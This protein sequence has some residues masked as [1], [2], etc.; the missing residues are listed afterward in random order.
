MTRKEIKHKVS[1]L[2]DLDI[3]VTVMSSTQKGVAA[4]TQTAAFKV[5]SKL[6]AISQHFTYSP[7]VV[8]KDLL[9]GVTDAYTRIYK[10]NT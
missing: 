2:P 7:R 4:Y 3:T 9:Q 5:N 8:S 6:Y 1:G 10:D